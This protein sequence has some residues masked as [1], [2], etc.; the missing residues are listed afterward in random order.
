MSEKKDNRV[1]KI[2]IGVLSLFLLVSIVYTFSFY[3]EKEE[4]VEII[5]KEKNRLKNELDRLQKK[6]EDIVID[7]SSLKKELTKE[8]KRISTLL[9][10]L[11]SSKMTNNQLQRYKIE[12]ELLRRQRQKLLKVVDS[13]SQKNKALQEVI[14]STSS[15]LQLNQQKSDSLSFE[16]QVL[17]SQVEKASVLQLSNLKA[18][19]VYIKDKD[20]LH[21]TNKASKT[22]QLRICFTLL[23]NELASQGYR[24]VFI[25]VINPKNK[26]LGSQELVSFGNKHLNYSVV[27]TILYQN[28]KL[29]TCI[30]FEVSPANIIQGR[31]I[32]N[33]FDGEHRMKTSTFFLK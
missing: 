21:P 6:Y 29:E 20:E 19:G 22:K 9:N 14:D 24:Q 32:V 5:S 26:L 8:K 18:E 12:A 15:V 27:N 23:K 10:S 31:Y 25:Q 1:L 30:L 17:E 33:V 2:L 3:Q 13:F 16:K 28:K 7:N 11:D 4:N